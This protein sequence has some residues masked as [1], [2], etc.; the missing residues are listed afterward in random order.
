VRSPG[1][2]RRVSRCA[3]RDLIW[4]VTG[5]TAAVC[6]WPDGAVGQELA[7][8]QAP[9]QY[10]RELRPGG[11]CWFRWQMADESSYT[12]GYDGW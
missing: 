4:T 9:S 6:A 10:R 7:R 11:A 1:L 3:G 8:R 2:R 5:V 12:Y